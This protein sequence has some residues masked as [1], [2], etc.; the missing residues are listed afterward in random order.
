[1]ISCIVRKMLYAWTMGFHDIKL[2]TN[3]ISKSIQVL[4]INCGLQIKM[5]FIGV[6][7]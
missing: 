3:I 7:N 6:Y 1:M 2:F 4:I 5:F